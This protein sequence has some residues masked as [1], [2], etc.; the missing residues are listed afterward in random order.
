ME[1]AVNLQQI[2]LE[3]QEGLH[4][5]QQGNQ[6]RLQLPQKADQRQSRICLDG[7]VINSLAF[8]LQEDGMHVLGYEIRDEKGQ[9]LESA[10]RVLMADHR[11]PVIALPQTLM[12]HSKTVCRPL[13]QDDNLAVWQAS[14]DGMTIG[15]LDAIEILPSMKT[16]EIMAADTF[17]NLSM[18]AMQIVQAPVLKAR[19]NEMEEIICQGNVL[20]LALE[21]SWQGISVEVDYGS[22]TESFA[23]E[24][25]ALSIPVLDGARS[26]RLRHPLMPEVPSWNLRFENGLE[27]SGPQEESRPGKPESEKPSQTGEEKPLPDADSGSDREEQP[28]A[29]LPEDPEEKD[30]DSEKGESAGGKDEITEDGAA[31]GSQN[32]DPDKQPD[33]D[34]GPD[35]KDED[36]KPDTDIGKEE[37]AGEK[38]D[39][40][41]SSKPAD[42]PEDRPQ[43]PAAGN[44]ENKTPA[45]D[46]T[47]PVKPAPQPEPRPVLTEK[48][49]QTEQPDAPVQN[50]QMPSVITQSESRPQSTPVKPAAPVK[51]VLKSEGKEHASDQKLLVCDP[52]AIELVVENGTVTTQSYLSMDSGRR[53]ASLEEALK[54]EEMPVVQLEASIAAEDGALSHNTW[55][56]IP[57]GDFAQGGLNLKEA[58]WPARFEMN[59][60]GMLQMNSGALRLPQAMLCQGFEELGT[61]SVR[62]GEELR[63]YIDHPAEDLDLQLDGKSVD[64]MIEKDELGQTYIPIEASS[65]LDIVLCGSDG[66]IDSWSVQVA[67]SNTGWLAAA[68]AGLGL[69]GLMGLRFRK[70][71]QR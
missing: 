19:M 69:L 3:Q 60:E 24:S 59:R 68:A 39:E 35:E 58:G 54:N 2:S 32:A 56:L 23:F 25:D 45:P 4:I 29:M 53:Y 10:E 40:K 50:V 6:I 18:Q 51:A 52:S 17:G 70:R 13:V 12:V 21:G 27:S 15:S 14:I 38:E 11:A 67:R 34:C 64:W 22:K 43:K 33:A 46:E 61:Q 66:L 41:P 20:A 63:L 30:E 47:K 37:D 36:E 1:N 31:D 8:D 49:V 9:I 62:Q 44:E 16:L 65:D 7:K 55:T 26:I 42:Q 5:E 57:A 28:D 48:P 71:E